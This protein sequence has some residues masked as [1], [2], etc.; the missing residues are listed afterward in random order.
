MKFP[1]GY[2]K[3]LKSEE[4]FEKAFMEAINDNL[5][6]PV[7]MAVVRVVSKKGIKIKAAQQILGLK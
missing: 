5:N 7:A 4:E 2:L 6:I 1:K 3:S